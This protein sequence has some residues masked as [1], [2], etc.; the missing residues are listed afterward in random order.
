[1]DQLKGIDTSHY[2]NFTLPLMQQT[3]KKNKLY[4]NFI[5][6]SE[7]ATIQDAKFADIWQMSR[8]AGLICGAYHFFRPLADVPAQVANFINQYR[9][10]SRAG[11]LPPVIDIEWA[12]GS[13]SEE[14]WA[15]LLPAQRVPKIKIFLSALEA[16][17]NTKPII[18]TAT[19]FWKEYIADQCS[20]EDI[21]YF[22]QYT[23]WIVDLSNTGK[24]P[25]PWQG[26]PAPFVQTHFGE[27][28]TTQE[29]Y[30]TCDQNIFNGSLKDL[31]NRTMPGFTVM[32]GFPF[33]NIV[34]DIQQKL[35]DK[36]LLKSSA[37]GLFGSNTEKAV[38]AFQ[39]END[40]FDNGIADAQTW[41]KLL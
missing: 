38:K 22:S 17:L 9:K 26:H 40:L 34:I 25:L 13:A 20:D 19:G 31:L 12:K 2:S 3:V 24:L 23:L 33:S 28:A 14:Q 37:D 4:F 10:V 1:M 8:K 6:A 18:Y 30:D 16:D 36:K 21:S 39:K 29:P 5:K 11:V 15:Q 27:M 35:I 41:N 32:K 7:G